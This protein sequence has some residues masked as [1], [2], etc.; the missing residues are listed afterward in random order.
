MAATQ[1][2]RDP[3]APLRVLAWRALALSGL[4]LPSRSAG[5]YRVSGALPY[6]ASVPPRLLACPTE[7]E[8]D[9]AGASA[10]CIAR[11][12]TR[13]PFLSMDGPETHASP[14]ATH[15]NNSTVWQPLRTQIV[16]DQP[17]S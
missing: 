15:A 11:R 6:V 2:T 10:R 12:L 8:I 4:E 16:P 17:M 14:M 1:A 9:R 7:R 13:P 3:T 5:L